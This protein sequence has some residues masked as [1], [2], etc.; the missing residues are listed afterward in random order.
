MGTESCLAQ[1]CCE[2][3]LLGS[4][5]CLERIHQWKSYQ[6][7]PVE[8]PDEPRKGMHLQ[9]PSGRARQA[10]SSDRL[11]CIFPLEGNS[12]ENFILG[13]R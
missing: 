2:P 13:S 7:A 6:L 5:V 9:A 10:V 3:V 12:S 1:T 11:C 4:L 8:E